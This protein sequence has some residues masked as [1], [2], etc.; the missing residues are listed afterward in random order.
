MSD[1]ASKRRYRPRLIRGR[2]RTSAPWPTVAAHPRHLDPMAGMPGVK[3]FQHELETLLRRVGRRFAVGTSLAV[4]PWEMVA[5]DGLLP[6]LIAF[7]EAESSK[8]RSARPALV[9]KRDEEA[10]VSFRIHRE[11]PGFRWDWALECVWEAISFIEPGPDG[12]IDLERWYGGV[13]WR[14]ITDCFGESGRI[15]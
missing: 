3:R 1:D 8:A 11:M 12:S 15:R 14:A 10:L 2:L 13:A 9:I 7:G 4:T 5:F 6:L